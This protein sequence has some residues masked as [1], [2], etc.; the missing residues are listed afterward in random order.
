MTPD[1]SS[2]LQTAC[3]ANG[4]IPGVWEAAP[5]YGSMLR[6]ASEGWDFLIEQIEGPGQYDRVLQSIG[7]FRDLYP[8]MQAAVISNFGG[9]DT[10]ALAA[11]LISA[12]LAC[13]VEC[14]VGENPMSTPARQVDFAARVLGWPGPQPMIG[15][16][17]GKTLADY[18]GW[19]TFSGASVYSA[20]YLL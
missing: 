17:S 15:L 7:P 10:A 14:F 16:G 4:V 3:R 18:P 6:R 11:P 9:M 12:G 2:R 13:L 8:S 5:D 19:E 1:L 20:E